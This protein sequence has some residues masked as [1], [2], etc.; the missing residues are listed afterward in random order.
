MEQLH[1]VSLNAVSEAFYIISN[2]VFLQIMVPLFPS[3]GSLKRTLLQ[4]TI[5][6]CKMGV[7]V[8]NLAV[9]FERI[10]M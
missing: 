10:E 2:R 7:R 3:N 1:I 5:L 8:E 6:T 9:I 4:L